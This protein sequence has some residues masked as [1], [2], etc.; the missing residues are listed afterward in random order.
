MNA[1][2]TRTKQKLCAANVLFFHQI[3]SQMFSVFFL[4]KLMSVFLFFSFIFCLFVYTLLSQWEM[5]PMGKCE[6]LNSSWKASCNRVALPNSN[7]LQSACWVFSCF[8]NPPRNSDM[9]YRICNMR[10]WSFLCVSIHTGV[11]H[12][13]NES[14]QHFD[15][16]K[17]S[18]I[19]LVLLTGFEPRVFGSRV[20]R[21]ANWTTP[22]L[23]QWHT[24]RKYDLHTLSV[25]CQI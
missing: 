25:L 5:F 2:F 23:R 21:S 9:D 4:N 6:S 19:R 13:D 20:R 12:T 14:A 16:E 8:R 1:F 10:T 7:E 18:Q 17:L 3:N 15:S 22:S 24:C 11:G